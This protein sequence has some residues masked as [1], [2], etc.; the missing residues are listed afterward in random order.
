VSS[1]VSHRQ[2]DDDLELAVDTEREWAVYRCAHGCF[3]VA[4]D[5]VTLTLT[6]DEFHALQDL[7]R[8]ACQRF[9]RPESQGIR[10]YARTDCSG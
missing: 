8:R 7:I 3:H 4:L 1:P 10:R 5:R 9:H 2:L 6:E